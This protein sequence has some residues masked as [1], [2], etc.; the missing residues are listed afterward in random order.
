MKKSKQLLLITALLF[1][2][3]LPVIAQQPTDINLHIPF[4]S[5]RRYVLCTVEWKRPVSAPAPEYFGKEQ[6][7]VA[8][9]ANV[10][11]RFEL[12]RIDERHTDFRTHGIHS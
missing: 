6:K 11:Q 4:R 10:Y 5:E 3:E 9:R 7:A 1:I 8:S 12:C 2:W